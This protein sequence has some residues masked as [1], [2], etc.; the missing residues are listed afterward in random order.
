MVENYDKEEEAQ[1]WLRWS[2]TSAFEAIFIS[3]PVEA[4][5]WYYNSCAA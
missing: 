2:P 4:L 1:D 3:A 5:T